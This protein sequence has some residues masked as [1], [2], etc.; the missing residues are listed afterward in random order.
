MTQLALTLDLVQRER[1]PPPAPPSAAEARGYHLSH[2]QRRWGYVEYEPRECK[3][4]I[5]GALSPEVWVGFISLAHTVKMP[6]HAVDHMLELLVRWGRIQQTELYYV[7][8]G[9]D[10]LVCPPMGKGGSYRG[11]EFGYRLRTPEAEEAP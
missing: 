5:L 8:K 3:R 1:R 7:D 11:F 6:S 2:A 10:R 9:E 4:R